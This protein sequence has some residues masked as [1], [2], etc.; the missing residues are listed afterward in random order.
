MKIQKKIALIV[1]AVFALFCIASC[2]AD[3]APAPSG[4][5]ST[6][7]SASSGIKAKIKV[8]SLAGPTGMGMVSLM[9]S[10]ENETS[11]NDYEFTLATSPDEIV[12]LLSSGGAD[13]AA[14]PANL[15]A[16]LYAK[17]HG[18]VQMAA[19]NTLSVLYILQKGTG[20]T[21][22][23][24]LE[25]KTI[26]ASG[27]G[28]TPEYVLNYILEANG[29]L[30]K[31]TVNYY[32]E[33]SEV[34]STLAAGKADIA[35][36]PEPYVTIAKSKVENLGIVLD[37]N[38]EWGKGLQNN[39]G[40]RALFRWA[41]SL[42][43]PEFAQENPEAVNAFLDEYYVSIEYVNRNTEQ[44][45]ALIAKYGILSDATCGSLRI[46]QLQHCLY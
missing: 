21:S 40:F 24:D 32:S 15:A 14:I 29:L 35:L 41:A 12:G 42:F 30:G 2:T 5:I 27:Q 10:D 8:A 46:T 31:V 7:A 11:T 16:T 45:A 4:S 33:H 19:I 20:I 9:E 18:G 36:L 3:V 39:G 37:I 44:A 25:G 13:I 17:T 6:G 28:S 43:A 1:C 38:A 34:V 26:A 22:V 23:A